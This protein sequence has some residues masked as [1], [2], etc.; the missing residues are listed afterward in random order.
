LALKDK[1]QG[2]DRI[3]ILMG[4]EVSF[5]SKKAFAQ[6]LAR[7]TERLEASLEAEKSKNDF[8]HGVPAIVAA[9]SP[10]RTCRTD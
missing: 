5:R 10:I 4:D 8:L 6:G 1:W 2:V 9:L 7:V 3:R